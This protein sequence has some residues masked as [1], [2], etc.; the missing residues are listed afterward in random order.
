MRQQFLTNLLLNVLQASL[1]FG[2]WY[3]ICELPG[4]NDA[5]CSNYFLQ[6]YQSGLLKVDDMTD[7]F[8]RALTVTILKLHKNLD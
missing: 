3:R 8:F 1:R 6:L 2:E 7:R 4:S 5:A